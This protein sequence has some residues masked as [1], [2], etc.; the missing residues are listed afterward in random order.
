M[1]DSPDNGARATP[2]RYRRMFAL[3]GALALISAIVAVVALYIS[4]GEFQLHAS[5]AMAIGVGL[6]VLLGGGLMALV[7]LS[8]GTGHDARVQGGDKRG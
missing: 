3:V 8:N 1:N 2:R 4:V 5:L 6:S 7:F